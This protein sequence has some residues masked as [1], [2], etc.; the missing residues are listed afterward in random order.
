MGERAGDYWQRRFRG[1]EGNNSHETCCQ[2]HSPRWTDPA[3][4]CAK[5]VSEKQFS[6]LKAMRN[7]QRSKEEETKR[8]GRP[9]LAVLGKVPCT[10]PSR[11]SSPGGPARGNVHV[12][13]DEEEKD[14]Y[15]LGQNRQ[16][17]CRSDSH[18]E[19]L[20]QAWTGKAEWRILPRFARPAPYLTSS[21]HVQF[22]FNTGL[23]CRVTSELLHHHLSFSVEIVGI[24][25]KCW[26]A[27]RCFFPD[28]SSVLAHFHK[29]FTGL[30]QASRHDMHLPFKVCVHPS[31]AYGCH[32]DPGHVLLSFI[33]RRGHLPS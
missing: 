32:P 17:Y 16:N 8:I 14:C 20:M 28:Q 25:T 1:A 4:R 18:L 29:P 22:L 15:D 24:F 26:H 11:Q 7:W 13:A 27:T 19:E 10:L 33:R 2:L 12:P 3:L 30:S 9:Q 5:K 21:M 31:L 23:S 6:L